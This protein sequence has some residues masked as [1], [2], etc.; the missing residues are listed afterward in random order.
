M[1]T[2]ESRS[3]VARER[4]EP[5]GEAGVDSGTLIV[6]DPCYIDADDAPIGDYTSGLKSDEWMGV[7]HHDKATMGHLTHGEVKGCV[8]FSTYYGDGTYKVVAV[9][10]RD[11]QLKR[12]EIMIGED[13]DDE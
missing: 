12:I 4:R 10:G 5:L 8:V 6:G 1:T 2:G 7:L 9:W 3:R 13:E 11:S